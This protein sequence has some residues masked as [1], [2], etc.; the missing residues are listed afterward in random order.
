MRIQRLSLKTTVLNRPSILVEAEVEAK[1][2]EDK[3]EVEAEIPTKA[4][5]AIRSLMTQTGPRKEEVIL[6]ARG[7]REDAKI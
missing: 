7:A 6:V 3:E 5:R 2:V 4:N 1:V